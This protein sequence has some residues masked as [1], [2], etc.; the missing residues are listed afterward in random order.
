[1][2]SNGHKKVQKKF[3]DPELEAEVY[4]AKENGLKPPTKLPSDTAKEKLQKD[5]DKSEEFGKLLLAS[6]CINH[7]FKLLM[8]HFQR[9]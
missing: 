7:F 8:A 6:S 2:S 1:M 4:Y 9:I 5:L 3:E